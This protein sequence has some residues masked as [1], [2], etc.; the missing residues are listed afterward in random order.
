MHRAG[1]NS[2]R[3]G[4]DTCSHPAHVALYARDA[5]GLEVPP[6]PSVPPRLL[7]EVGDHS[8][9]LA[10]DRRL[11]A[12]EEW[13]SWWNAILRLEGARENGTLGLPSG[14]IERVEALAGAYRGLLDWPD[15]DALADRP[16]LREAV[17]LSQEDARQWRIERSR[18]AALQERGIPPDARELFRQSAEAVAQR[19]GVALD[20]LRAGLLVIDVEG[21]WADLSAPGVLVCSSAAANDSRRLATLIEEVFVSGL[22]ATAV[23]LPVAQPRWRPLPASVI[24]EPLVL[25]AGPGPALTCER[26]L[27][28]PDGFELEIRLGVESL[29]PV[30]MADASPLTP[31]AH[32]RWQVP[33]RD[34][35][36][37]PDRFAGLQVGLEFADGRNVLNRDLHASYQ[38]GEEYSPIVLSRF[39]RKEPDENS[40]W[41]WVMPLPP[42]G[43]VRLT[44]SWPGERTASASAAFEGADVCPAKIG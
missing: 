9:E 18:D 16:A 22:D 3:V 38:P 29:P 13:L 20:R 31:A 15:L 44:V 8:E 5:C 42:A 14:G 19:L 7:G 21:D 43:E 34:I 35:W 27:A 12:G 25:W 40:L 37:R 36:G 4:I 10:P 33:T 26:V 17:R 24:R 23:P 11:L 41:L 2:W 28:C 39:F 1:E 6:D 30:P 32:D